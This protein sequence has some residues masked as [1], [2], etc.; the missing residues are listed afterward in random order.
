[1]DFRR[2][3]TAVAL[4]FLIL[5]LFMMP[6]QDALIFSILKGIAI[7]G[8]AMVFIAYAF[9]SILKFNSDENNDEDKQKTAES[10]FGL[11]SVVKSHYERLL[12][13]V[14]NLVSA[15]NPAYSTGVYM[16]DKEGQGYTRQDSS[17]NDLSSFITEKNSIVTEIIHQNK[18]VILKK[19]KHHEGWAEIL[20]ER[21]WRGSETILGFPISFSGHIVGAM[22]VFTDHFSSINDQ[23]IHIIEKLGEII[24]HGMTDLEQMESLMVDNY[25]NSRVTNLFDQ[26]EVKSDQSELFE[27]IRGLCRA[28][29]Q[30]DKLTITMVESDQSTAKIKLVDGLHDDADEG[31]SFNMIN[32][33]HGLAVQENRMIHSNTW[34]DEFPEMNR[35]NPNDR[36]TFNFMSVLSMP[37]RSNG[38]AVGAISLER[39]KSKKYTDTDSR[40]FELLCGTVSSILNWQQ[41]YNRVHNSSIHDGL[42]GLLNHKAFLDRFE[43]E[44]SRAG[45]FN[46]MLGLVILDLDKFKSINDSYGHLYGDYVL[47]EVSSIIKENVRA[48]DVVGRYGGE[49]FA[50]LLVN[51]DIQQ[52]IPLAERIVRKISEKTFLKNGIAVN[53]TISA[54]MSG[55]PIHADQVRELISKADKAMY[56]TKRIGGNS[57]TISE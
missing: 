2:Q 27:S 40:L 11:S 36:D 39:L 35:F 1:M 28:F 30:Y 12:T 43:E 57:V 20:G 5:Y 18:P 6:N 19:N 15:V 8:L 44:V 41:E 7:G 13:Q 37:L 16:L 47:E 53:V 22:L 26:L 10:E 54:G 25:F 55:F 34:F 32:T 14:V 42:T 21:S 17:E 31:Q 56:E 38:K 49:E 23:D 33:L 3:I 9:P 4:F 29:F 45:R 46:H 48:I 51:T 24:T 50:V 52:C